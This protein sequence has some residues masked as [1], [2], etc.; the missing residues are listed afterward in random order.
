MAGGR[1]D[2]GRRPRKAT[3]AWRYRLVLHSLSDSGGFRSAMYDI[4]Y[5]SQP[6]VDPTKMTVNECVSPA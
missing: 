2:D 3:C 4:D 6:V 1:I 5:E